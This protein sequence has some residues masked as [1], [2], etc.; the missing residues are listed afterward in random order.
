MKTKNKS[1]IIISEKKQTTQLQ[2]WV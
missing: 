2:A 1:K